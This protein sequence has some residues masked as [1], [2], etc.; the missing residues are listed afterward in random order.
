MEEAPRGLPAWSRSLL[1]EVGRHGSSVVALSG[2]VDSALVAWAAREALP[3]RSVAVT[4]TSPALAR[5]ERDR[6]RAVAEF[7][8]LPHREVPVDP[9]KDPR[10]AANPR[11]RCYFCR[12][13]E[14]D[15]L[16]EI[17]R[18]LGY[19]VVM[20]G[21]HRDDLGEDRPGL[22]ALAERGVVHPLLEVG[23]GKQEIRALALAVGL[24]NHDA[25]SNSCLASRV[26]H[27]EPISV[28]ILERV[29]RAESFLADLGFRQV[30]VRTRSGEARVEVEPSQVSRL[31]SPDTSQ[32]VRRH[33][34][35]LGFTSVELDPYG[36][37]PSGARIPSGKLLPVVQEP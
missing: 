11:D 3:D 25:P 19:A 24:P 26:A 8:G 6:A 13:Q 7:L 31:R 28:E 5:G 30:R 35:S 29:E 12:A 36:Y 15:A 23:A 18:S 20:D 37:R 1:Q 14:G 32:K 2:G 22:R 10:Y 16:G 27:G 9:L 33:L 17:A 21:V 4:I 34:Q